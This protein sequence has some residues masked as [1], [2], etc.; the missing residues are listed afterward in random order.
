MKSDCFPD[1]ERFLKNQVQNIST[2]VCQRTADE[3]QVK[4]IQK[5]EKAGGLELNRAKYL[6]GGGD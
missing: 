2:L 6:K 3:R 5:R 1:S 4:G